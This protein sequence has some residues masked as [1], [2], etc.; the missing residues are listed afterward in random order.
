MTK[1]I[2]LQM[3]D[4]RYVC[5]M[6]YILFYITI[7]LCVIGCSKPEPKRIDVL[8]YADSLIRSK[9]AD[10][11]LAL[12]KHYNLHCFNTLSQRAKY[13]LLF[14]QATNKNYIV[15]NSDSL[16]RMAVAY[17]D[18]TNNDVEM[19]GKAH[20]Y[21]G[22]YYMDKDS[23]LAT[24]RELLYALPLIEKTNNYD[25]KSCVISNMALLCYDHGLYE[26]ADS[27][28]KSVM[29]LEKEN[30]DIEG[31]SLSNKM[32]GMVY[33]EWK[34]RGHI[35]KSEQYLQKAYALSKHIN[36]KR[37]KLSIIGVLSELYN[38]KHQYKISNFYAYQGLSLTSDPT[39]TFGYYLNLGNN[40]NAMGQYD[41]AIYYLKKALR[42]GNVYTKEDIYKNLLYIAKKRKNVRDIIRYS[43]LYDHYKDST[44]QREHPIEVQAALK[45]MIYKQSQQ[46]YNANVY[47]WSVLLYVCVAVIV[48]ILFMVLYLRYK[49]RKKF[50][51]FVGRYRKLRD[52][53]DVAHRQIETSKR[54]VDVLRQEMDIA[55][56]E[57]MKTYY[58]EML[59]LQKQRQKELAEKLQRKDEEIAKISRSRGE[60]LVRMSVI[61]EEFRQIK[62]HNLQGAG[63]VRMPTAEQWKRLLEEINYVRSGEKFEK[64][65]VM[66]Y[67]GMEEEDIYFCCLV[68]IGVK[69]T[70]IARVMGCS[71]RTIY[72][73]SEKMEKKMNMLSKTKF[74]E[75]LSK[76]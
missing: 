34:I 31:L 48:L 65:L 69:Y 62:L 1:Y 74:R 36:N 35:T 59:E 4:K 56:P 47:R 19:Q 27:L 53:I 51:E 18:K 61:Y 37:I 45:D 66:Q 44:R 67:G 72:A 26:E 75:V 11:A 42:Y 60:E 68:R 76:I 22:M 43:D 3:K 33:G 73:R 32:L 38:Y 64:A 50:K 41:S 20:Y 25:L 49:S 40:C 54:N 9:R 24:V 14:I 15:N 5:L 63:N 21:W 46:R 16:I 39:L 52:E 71:V 7:A 30:H 23:A 13:A 70:D 55:E 58:V 17:Y 12:L 29:V 57:K 6:K 2:S 8:T 10:K 28:Y